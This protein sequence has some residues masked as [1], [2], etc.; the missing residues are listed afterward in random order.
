MQWAVHLL[1]R[2]LGVVHGLA[3]LVGHEEE[4][5]RKGRVQLQNITNGEKAAG[6]VYISNKSRCQLGL[7]SWQS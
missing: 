5:Q 1:K 6:K 3:V 4:P 7:A 2:P